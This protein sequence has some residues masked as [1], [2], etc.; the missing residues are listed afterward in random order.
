MGDRAKDDGTDDGRDNEYNA[1]IA[2]QED[3]GKRPK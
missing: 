3:D 2:L 1:F